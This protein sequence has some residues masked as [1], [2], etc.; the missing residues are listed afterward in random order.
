MWFILKVM[1]KWFNYSQELSGKY[2]RAA[3]IAVFQGN[4]PRAN[5]SLRFGANDA[6]KNNDKL[7]GWFVNS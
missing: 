7:R 1:L 5:S 6:M 2:E 3:A 4:L